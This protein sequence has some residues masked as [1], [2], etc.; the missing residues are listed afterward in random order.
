MSHSYTK[1]PDSE[2]DEP[3]HHVESIIFTTNNTWSADSITDR[4]ALTSDW[5]ELGDENDAFAPSTT[6]ITAATSTAAAAAGPSQQQSL[7]QSHQQSRWNSNSGLPDYRQHGLGR[8]LNP[9]LSLISSLPIATSS[10]TT[11]SSPSDPSLD[12]VSQSSTSGPSAPTRRPA[13]P[14][15]SDG[16]FANISAKPEIESRKE[17]DQ[18]PPAYDSAVQDITPPYFEMTVTTPVVFGDEIVVDGIPVGNF[19]QFL[20]NVVVAVSFQFLGVLLTYL[21]HNSHA[22][23]AGSMVGL[24]ITLLNF[25]LRMRGDLDSIF[26]GGSDS[27]GEI[28]QIDKLPSVDDTGYIS[29]NPYGASTDSA[30]MDWLETDM[31]NRWVSLILMV[32]GWM[33]IV[34]ALAEYATAKRTERV[35]RVQPADSRELYIEHEV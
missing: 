18:H 24:G 26:G 5:T 30:Q 28:T 31:E 21:L 20:W 27:A 16:V 2:Q 32:A 12:G 14:T 8:F 6:A 3:Q 33:I 29:G 17:D 19:F 1:V 7:S 10:S 25:G 11:T 9:L 35:I 23:K 15:T 13:R 22:S 4:T 34:K